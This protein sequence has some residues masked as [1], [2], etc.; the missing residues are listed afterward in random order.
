MDLDRHFV[1]GDGL[2]MRVPR[3]GEG[4]AVGESEEDMHW[5]FARYHRLNRRM[6]PARACP[7]RPDQ[8][9]PV[10]AVRVVVPGATRLFRSGVA[11]RPQKRP[12]V[13]PVVV[14]DW[15][16]MGTGAPRQRLLLRPKL[17][18]G[19]VPKIAP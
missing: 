8:V 7:T 11:I 12:S 2:G 19:P 13:S 6:V 4:F 9:V 1:L 10:E 18:R 17:D 5:K 14:L 3:I 16:G 15:W